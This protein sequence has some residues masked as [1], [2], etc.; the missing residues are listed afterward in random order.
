MFGNDEIAYKSAEN[1]PPPLENDIFNI[2]GNNA[3]NITD[4]IRDL[5]IS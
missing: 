3:L 5:D 1:N 4:I 2:P